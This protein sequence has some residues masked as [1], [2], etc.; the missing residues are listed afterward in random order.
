MS[1]GGARAPKSLARENRARGTCGLCG[2]RGRL[3][4]TH[5]PPRCAG[6]RGSV[7]RFTIVS[8]PDR[9]AASST[10][11]IGGVHFFG[12]C[13]RCNSTVQAR[14]DGAYCELAKAF[15]PLAIRTALH[16]PSQIGTPA[17]DFKPGAVA[18]G[19]LA[20]CFALNPN[21][22]N[23]Y[24]ALA[25]QLL[26]N[27][28]Q[29]YLPGNLSL[30]LAVTPGPYA[31]VTGSIGGFYMFRPKVNG[32][33]V[34]IMS[35]AQ[36]YFPPLAWQ[37]ADLPESVLLQ[38]QRW[39]HVSQWLHR[40]EEETAVLADLVPEL[41][42]VLHP[43]REPAGMQDWTELLAGEACFIVESENAVAAEWS[44]SE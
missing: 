29:V 35:M 42:F 17:V 18:R 43:T 10:K 16:L 5:V 27:E 21:M 23:V 40:T 31:R 19:V 1:R 22:R 2:Y 44:D 8:D 25:H 15:W 13:A 41:P 36:I 12:L 37:L 11:R 34:G 39:S 26:A 33:N 30:H 24:P 20:A 38:Q 14:W 7:K 3:T 6:N 9:R 4:K 32:R 28:K